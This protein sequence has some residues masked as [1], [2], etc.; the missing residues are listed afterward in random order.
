[1]SYSEFHW[2]LVN[3]MARLFGLMSLFA[4][5]GCAYSAVLL[6]LHPEDSASIPSASG[7]AFADA[8]GVA[9]IAGI[10]GVLFV[11]VRVKPFRPD[12]PFITSRAEGRRGWWTGQPKPRGNVLR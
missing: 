7:S 10:I 9:I 8:V 1:M 5:L 4:S 11:F 2:R 12:L 6:W 3:I